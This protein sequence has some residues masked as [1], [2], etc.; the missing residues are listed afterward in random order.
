ML[1]GS[2]LPSVP[3]SGNEVMK[4]KTL[5]LKRDGN[6]NHDRVPFFLIHSNSR[7]Q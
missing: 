5:K 4:L 3:A 7:P 1:L 2:A 6:F